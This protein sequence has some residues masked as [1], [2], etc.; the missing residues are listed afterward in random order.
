MRSPFRLYVSPLSTFELVDFY[1]IQYE[2][3]AVEGDLDVV[4]FY[5]A[6]STIQ[7]LTVTQ[8]LSERTRMN[9]SAKTENSVTMGKAFTFGEQGSNLNTT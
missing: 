1:E 8:Y 7:E 6:A 4:I 5:P 9:T 3:Q 2:G